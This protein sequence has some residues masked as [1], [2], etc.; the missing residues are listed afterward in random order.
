MKLVM[1][2]LSSHQSVEDNDQVN[3]PDNYP[4]TQLQFIRIR[5]LLLVILKQFYSMLYSLKYMIN[6]LYKYIGSCNYL[7]YQYMAF[8]TLSLLH[9]Y[10]KENFPSIV[11]MFGFAIVGEQFDLPDAS[12][13]CRP[14]DPFRRIAMSI[15]IFLASVG[16][17]LERERVIAR[18][19]LSLGHCCIICLVY[20]Q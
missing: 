13:Q 6:I 2:L 12:E 10:Q 16:Y 7:I 1:S 15:R 3:K 19:H 9:N 8:S 17:F 11:S 18:L 5:T 4:M 20:F 14:T